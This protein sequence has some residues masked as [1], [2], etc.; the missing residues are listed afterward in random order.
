MST[1]PVPI[2]ASCSGAVGMGTAGATLGV[3]CMN[4]QVSI[5]IPIKDLLQTLARLGD[6]KTPS[7]S[8]IP[9]QPGPVAFGGRAPG[10][11]VPAAG[12]W[13]ELPAP[14]AA[15]AGPV[16][17]VDQRVQVTRMPR[18]VSPA[19]IKGVFEKQVGPVVDC[20]IAEGVAILYFSTRT[21]AQRA[22]AFY[23]GGILEIQSDHEHEALE[24][25]LQAGSGKAMAEEQAVVVV[26]MQQHS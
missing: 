13:E 7:M 6:S 23:D 21:D 26:G 20:S 12:T 3:P 24:G 5:S 18:S 14:V 10:L 2:W 25:V 17:G 9:S 15:P 8:S 19:Q 22:V 16:K 1:F 4:L 11:P